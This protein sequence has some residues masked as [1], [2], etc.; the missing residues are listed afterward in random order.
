M[1][2]LS[3]NSGGRWKHPPEFANRVFLIGGDFANSIKASIFPK[4]WRARARFDCAFSSVKWYN[5]FEAIVSYTRLLI[6]YWQESMGTIRL[7]LLG[8]P[9]IEVDS[10]PVPPFKSRK[11]FALL[12]FLALNPGVHP[13][14]Q[15]A[16]L[17]WSDLPEKR[18]LDNLR[19]ALW[20]LNQVL[21][22][23]VLQADRVNVHFECH[24]DCHLDV[25]DFSNAIRAAERQAAPSGADAV[26]NLERAVVLY[27]GDLLT[28]FEL[29]GAPLFDEW[30]QRERAHL[31]EIAIDALHRLAQH[32][33]AHHQLP[34]GIATTRRLLEMDPWREEAHR[35][36]MRLLARAGQRTHALAQYET[37]R[38]ILRAELDVEPAAATT[39]LAER[40]RLA[41]ALPRHNLP[42]IWT[43]FI[44]RTAELAELEAL[45]A[46][47]A[48]RLLTLV[49]AGG[50]GKTRL[51]LEIAARR[52]NDFLHGVR[53]VALASLAA[54]EFL[55]AAIA[56]QI[57]MTVSDASDPKT[58]LLNYL[59]EKDM[60]IVLD[61]F[62]RL[63]EGAEWLVE[64]LKHAPDVKILVTSQR[65]L[66]LQAEWLFDVRG[67]NFPAS[68]FALPAA[69]AENRLNG[70]GLQRDA[71]DFFEA[72]ARR[73]QWRFALAPA[74]LPHAI[75]I[76][77]LVDGSPLGIELAA[78]W[79]R[80]FTC[81][82]IAARI[83]RDADFLWTT[84]Q[85]LPE[86][87]RSLRAVF[88]YAWNLLEVE[89]R[90]VFC[91]LAVLR[92]AFSQTAAEHI[93]GATP[94]HLDA[95]SALSLVR[96]DP[97]G[98]YH[99]PETL[100]QYAGEKLR[101]DGA[102]DAATHAAH[103]RYL[104]AWLVRQQPTLR[105]AERVTLDQIAREIENIRAGWDWA[106]ARDPSLVSG[107]AIESLGLY[108]EM[109]NWAR[110]GNARMARAARA[111]AADPLRA[112]KALLWQG[113]F[114]LRLA[115]YATAQAV[116]QDALAHLPAETAPSDHAF[117]LNH[118]GSVAERLG[119]R[120][121]AR[122]HLEASLRV[123]RQAGD[124]WA[125]ARALNNLGF[126]CH[127]AGEHVTARQLL[128]ASLAL[129]RQL[130]DQPGAAKTL[131]NLALTLDALAEPHA[132]RQAYLASLALFREQEN[133][134]GI[135]VCLNNLGFGALRQQDHEQAHRLFVDA[136][137]IRREI[138]DP[139]GIAV[140]LEN[141][142]AVACARGQYADARGYYRR[143]L[144]LASEIRAVRRSVETLVG[145][146]TLYARQ[147]Q[148]DR[149]RA[150][151]LL[152]FALQH[153]ALG[154]ETRAAGEALRAELQTQVAPT[155]FAAVQ[156]SGQAQTLEGLIE[157]ILCS[158][159]LG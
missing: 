154:Q 42:T 11:V 80:Y 75:R 25:D 13:R 89:E 147:P 27:R 37:C 121:Q 153:P 88:D 140:A 87:H 59:R 30:L 53:Y 64:V 106:L 95:L 81:A 109:R 74:D 132:A 96:R 156:A 73:A 92:G 145:V 90:V 54:P 56:D 1:W 29:G 112:G 127:L 144:K 158:E 151:E 119:N 3:A 47:P 101:A 122:T 137:T 114:A 51:A 14:S 62:E 46:Q 149:A 16:G 141:L 104:I 52:V 39:L 102:I 116:L 19:F 36:M 21:G 113:V 134:L 34:A 98:T 129:R 71:L 123:A 142:G 15:I 32:Y 115:D 124:D 57:G 86:R 110:E 67:L 148:P 103:A 55:G 4:T 146:A 2:I 72:C 79:T 143:A 70:A 31:R 61:N 22:A 5:T 107:A 77:Q 135:A 99:L 85:D 82:E 157:K 41:D 20:N 33:A 69:D 18:A 65:R 94:A 23:I 68:S 150:V 28:G 60:L 159:S 48:C 93:A 100:R 44:G 66:N 50:N 6:V 9:S 138:G 84:Q 152:A 49:G 63:V 8:A 43:P 136:L 130:A 10:Q 17:L 125:V 76:C 45:L 126:I 155:V 83:E 38:R 139:W 40:I 108:F 118:L 78:A 58:Q 117:A 128:D 26:A 131:S 91:R 12:V 97:D 133:R 120:E 7:R 24:A 35:Q 105:Q 111:L